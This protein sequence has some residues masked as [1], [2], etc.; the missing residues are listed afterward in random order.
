M[1]ESLI[2]IMKLI[3][4]DDKSGKAQGFSPG[5]RASISCPVL[6]CIF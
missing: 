5:M 6:V 4:Y 2:Q 1:S 3:H